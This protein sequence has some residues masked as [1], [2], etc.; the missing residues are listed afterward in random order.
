MRFEAPAPRD[1]RYRLM[2]EGDHTLRPA[3]PPDWWQGRRVRGVPLGRQPASND[4]AH[5]RR[6]GDTT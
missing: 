2:F 6:I 1:N 5:R 3:T 4:V